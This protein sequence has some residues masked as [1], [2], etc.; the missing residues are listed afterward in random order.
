M[1]E[2]VNIYDLFINVFKR[3]DLTEI[4]RVQSRALYRLNSGT[5]NI[6]TCRNHALNMSDL[7]MSN[8]RINYIQDLIESADFN[9]VMAVEVFNFFFN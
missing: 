7:V 5:I 6:N 4:T 2:A 8:Q 1:Q 9:P 3:D